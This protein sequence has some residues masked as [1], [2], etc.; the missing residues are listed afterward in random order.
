MADTGLARRKAILAWMGIA[1]AIG[2]IGLWAMAIAS[3][4]FYLSFDP[5]VVVA[6]VAVLTV[7]GTW[8]WRARDARRPT[9]TINCLT[10]AGQIA[11]LVLAYIVFFWAFQH[12]YPPDV[13]CQTCQG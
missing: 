13:P 12:I 9:L 5:Y 2:T 8:F 3:L 7:G 6:L 11:A 10:F 1:F 4:D